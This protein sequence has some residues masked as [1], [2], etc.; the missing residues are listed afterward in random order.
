MTITEI[1]V[2][3]E[4]QLVKLLDQSKDF[5]YFDCFVKNSQFGFNYDANDFFRLNLWSDNHHTYKSI[6]EMRKQIIRSAKRNQ[7]NDVSIN[8]VLKG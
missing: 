2:Q 5:R 3:T 4:E 8:I 1:K 7:Y 6:D